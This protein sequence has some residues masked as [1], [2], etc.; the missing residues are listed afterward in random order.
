MS[1]S[2][3][4]C[5]AKLGWNLACYVT[6][7]W[8]Y[9]MTCHKAIM[10]N[11]TSS[12]KPEVYNIS[13]RRQTR[14]E[15]RPLATCRKIWWVRPRHFRVM[16]A[17]RQT[18]TQTNVLITISLSSAF[19]CRAGSGYPYWYPVL[20]NSRGG[21]PLPSSRFVITYMYCD[22]SFPSPWH[23]LSAAPCLSGATLLSTLEGVPLSATRGRRWSP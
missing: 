20:G 21:F 18:D 9:T 23:C 6:A 5:R 22:Q 2:G 11:M 7:A 19:C 3:I 8:E 13:Q 15:P 4:Y 14:T 12:T 1:T 10:G 17:D 16:L